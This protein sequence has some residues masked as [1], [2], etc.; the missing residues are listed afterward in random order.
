MTYEEAQGIVSRPGRFEGC[1]PWIVMAYED[2]LNGCWEEEGQGES[3]VAVSDDD[4]KDWKLSPDTV[5]VSL[6]EDSQGFVY[7]TEFTADSY[8]EY[9]N[10][11]RVEANDRRF[12]E[13]EVY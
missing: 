7:G 11:L 4:I 13:E 6:Y 5:A 1:L 8:D 2:S 12:D 10:E 3:H 9:L